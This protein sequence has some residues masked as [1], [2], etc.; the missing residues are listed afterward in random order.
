[1]ALGCASLMRLATKTQRTR[2]INDA[3]D[4]GVRH[5]D[6]A[7]MY[8]LG[9]AERELGRALGSRRD[10]VT[11]S[12]KF[13]LEASGLGR[14]LAPVQ[15]PLRATLNALEPLRRSVK[16]NG[17]AFRADGRYDSETAS[18]HLNESLRALGTDYV[19]ILFLHGGSSVKDGQYAELIGFLEAARAAGKIRA[20]G[21]STES[22]VAAELTQSIQGTV[23]QM[24]RTVADPESVV[25]TRDGA[26]YSFFGVIQPALG[27]LSQSAAADPDRALAFSRQCGVDLRDRASVG[28]LLI[29]EA[30]YAAG[31][32]KV[33]IG[34]TSS[35]HL[36]AAVSAPARFS[37]ETHIAF[38]D[39]AHQAVHA[40]ALP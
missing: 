18:R 15:G 34:T 31:R 4:L 33:I 22:N 23:V 2:L 38:R 11:I 26:N 36:A 30:V 6:V 28:D 7:R 13:G 12:T 35:V 25:A 40:S 1:V 21:A 5:F 24:R 20:W 3:L 16:N 19:D 10:R 8:G 39:F 9:R 37:A 29:A 27:I 14:G 17:P 32:G